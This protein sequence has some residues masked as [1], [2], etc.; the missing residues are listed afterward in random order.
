MGQTHGL[1]LAFA[2]LFSLNVPSKLHSSSPVLPSA[3]FLK[4][5]ISLLLVGHE[6]KLDPRAG[7]NCEAGA[8]CPQA[9]RKGML[10]SSRSSNKG[11][12]L[13]QD[14]VC[15]YLMVQKCTLDV[16]KHLKST[17]QS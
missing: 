2:G 13:K 3:T 9:Q 12:K 8:A 7:L 16:F 5:G 17:L 4:R 15:L 10:P 14:S 11:Q 1:R 6:T